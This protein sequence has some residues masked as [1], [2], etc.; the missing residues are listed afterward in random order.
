MK[1]R[2]LLVLASI[3]LSQSFYAQDFTITG[4]LLDSVRKTPL[5]S[6]TLVVE[7]VKDSSMIT[8]TIT[9][10]AGDFELAGK[11]YQEEV[12]LYVSFVGYQ[13]YSKRIS[14]VQNRSISLGD[15]A[16]STDLNTLSNVLIKAR[17]AP[18][19]IKKDTL[20][21]NAASFRTKK[22]ANVEDLLR[23]LPGVEVDAQGAIT[24][25]G[26][27]VNRVLVNGKPFFGD[28]PTIAT[29]NLTKEIVEK[30]QVVDT[31]TESEAYTGEQGDNQ[32][33][34]VNI[35]IDKDKNKGFFGRFAAGGGTDDRFEYAGF[36]N[37]F[38][39]DR[40]I[41][42]LGGGNNINSPG[43]SFGEIDK[44]YG[45]RRYGDFFSG[46]GITNSRVGGVNYVDVLGE[47]NDLNVDY[48]YDS[49]NSFVERDERREVTLPNRQFL[50]T[51]SS[52]RDN[53]ETNH[54]VNSRFEVHLDSTFLIEFRPNFSYSEG[55]NRF[56]SEEETLDSLQQLTNS[57]SVRNESFRNERD[58]DNR[59]SATKKYGNGGG[60][61][62]VRMD[63]D[64]TDRDSEALQRSNT[65]IFGD[66]PET[67]NRDQITDGA[68][69]NN[70]LGLSAD[71]RIPLIAEKFFLRAEY[72]YENSRREDR[73]S[74]FDFNEET[75]QYSD[76]NQVQSIDFT[77]N[78][79]LSRPELGFSFDDEKIRARAS[80][81]YVSRTLESSDGLRDIDFTNDFNALELD[82]NLD[83]EFS[84]KAGLFSG[85]NLDNNTPGIRQLS[86]YIDV[87]NPLNTVQG[88]PDLKPS[89]RHSLYLGFRDFDWQSRTG[90]NTFVTADFT[91]DQVVSRSEI[92]DAN[93]R[94]TTFANVD[95]VYS[96]G[97]R[98]SYRKEIEIDTLHRLRYEV[99]VRVNLDRNVNFNNSVQYS[100]NNTRYEPRL[101]LRY[102]WKDILE[103]RPE[104]R[105]A[106]T[107][108]TFNLARFEDRVFT[109]HELRVRASTFWP[110]ELEW[111][112]DIRF[113]T[114][115]NVAAGFQ[116]NAVFW[117]ST[118]AYSVWKEKGTIRLKAFDILNQN[119]NAQR[120]AT[121][122][123]VQDVQSTVLQRYFMLSF[124]YKFNTLGKKGEIRSWGR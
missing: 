7:T 123:Y 17:A 121:A 55:S 79:R 66:D 108:N 44:I 28:D 29:R 117:N 113:I 59:I 64:I 88:N 14:L 75:Q 120:T 80:A 46:D 98:I 97:G 112:N 58:F 82:V 96:L 9:D 23:E 3:I 100:S 47:K 48:F 8:Y 31:K 105:P 102:R 43:F 54:S 52:R 12:N 50:S 74:V 67:I 72:D 56:R 37:Y 116:Q 111:E 103:L 93:V 81:A 22:D 18:I 21:F 19:N 53:S 73:Q 57:S 86:P 99:G 115:P 95:G 2:Y 10:A 13:P 27:P 5:E 69:S 36:A 32:N 83:V 118:L 78:N 6:A 62:R 122:D 84:N 34:T 11:A 110:K 42:V 92:S 76:F 60:F 20:E 68:E 71:W 119:T 114:N 89:N 124:S 61:I 51:S 87:S 101:E 38:D 30:I 63:N 45:R 35:T 25:N 94:T 106:F 49:A 109:R 77:N 41:S 1:L 24:I 16:L 26:K 33:K 40:R 4:T 39:N 15:V 65:E 91:N 107:R 70:G 90:F 104:Y 85:Y